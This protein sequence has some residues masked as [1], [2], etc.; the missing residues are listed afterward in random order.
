MPDV[1]ISKEFFYIKKLHKV[2]KGRNRN[3]FKLTSVVGRRSDAFVYVLSGTCYEG[4][5]ISLLF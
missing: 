3:H 4:R 1:D 2:I 5:K